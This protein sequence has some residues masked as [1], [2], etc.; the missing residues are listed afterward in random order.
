MEIFARVWLAKIKPPPKIS[1]RTVSWILTLVWGQEYGGQS[2][3]R[4]NCLPPQPP[5]P[6]PPPPPQKKKR[7]RRKQKR[8]DQGWGSVFIKKH[9]ILNCMDYGNEANRLL[10]W[11]YISF[12]PTHLITWSRGW[13]E[14]SPHPHPKHPSILLAHSERRPQILIPK[15]K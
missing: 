6:P 10:R 4:F 1:A 13:R 15:R 2:L 5:P 11:K 7:R 8:I 9:D 14:Q 3:Q 12:F